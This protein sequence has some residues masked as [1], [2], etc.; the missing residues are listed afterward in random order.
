MFRLT[1]PSHN[2]RLYLG[3]GL[4]SYATKQHYHCQ[5]P[6]ACSFISSVSLSDCVGVSG[7]WIPLLS[8]TPL[9][10]SLLP[11][12]R[13]SADLAWGHCGPWPSGPL[14]CVCVYVCCPLLPSLPRCVI[15]GICV[16]LCLPGPLDAGGNRMREDQL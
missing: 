10:L 3:W 2:M 6:F 8:L 12:H 5:D 15:G 14:V 9:P 7:A 11:T 13:L 1:S 4:S 16:R